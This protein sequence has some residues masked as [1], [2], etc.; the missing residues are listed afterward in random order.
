MAAGRRRVEAGRRRRAWVSLAHRRAFAGVDPDG[1]GGSDRAPRSGDPRPTDAIV[2]SAAL[3]AGS[4]DPLRLR[5]EWAF[6]ASSCLTSSALKA[7]ASSRTAH[8]SPRPR[9]AL[10]SP[11]DRRELEST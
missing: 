6:L 3:I 10:V 4:E 8:F 1:S 7:G 5:P 11:R 9:Q 2:N